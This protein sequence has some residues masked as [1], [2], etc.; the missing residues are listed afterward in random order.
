[1]GEEQQVSGHEGGEIVAIRDTARSKR[2]L[3]R[4]GHGPFRHARSGKMNAVRQYR[5][6]RHPVQ[7]FAGLSNSRSIAVAPPAAPTSCF[8]KRR[9]NPQPKLSPRWRAAPRAIEDAP[10]AERVTS[11]SDPSCRAVPSVRRSRVSSSMYSTQLHAFRTHAWVCIE[12]PT[13]KVR[14][15]ARRARLA[16]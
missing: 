6:G 10:L 15:A 12:I 3:G 14:C 8:S 9:E 5:R 1:M 16:R 4:P 7:R 11:R 13:M 2:I